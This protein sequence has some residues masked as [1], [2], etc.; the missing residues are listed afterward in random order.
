MSIHVIPQDLPSETPILGLQHA[1]W[2]GGDHGLRQLSL[3]RQTIALDAATPPHRH[4]CE[5]LVMCCCGSG[6]L[7]IG[8]EV[9]RFGTNQTAAVPR[10]VVHQLFNVG[11]QPLEI[12]AVLAATPVEVYLPDGRKLDLPWRT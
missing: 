3:W 1:T 2:A 7:R 4:D 12:I 6:E 8:A 10:N 5:E 9:D 11:A